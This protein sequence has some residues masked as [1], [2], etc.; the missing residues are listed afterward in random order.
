MSINN[1]IGSNPLVS[2]IIP[3]FNHGM[4]LHKAIES[5]LRQTYPSTEIIVVD[6]GSMDN[7]KAV[8]NQYPGVKYIYQQNQGLSAARNTG[9]KH[10]SGDF[11]VFLDADDW[12]YPRGIEIN[13]SYLVKNQDAAFVSGLYDAVYVEENAIREGKHEVNSDHYK[14]LLQCNYIGMIAAVIFRQWV[15]KEF[16]YDTSLRNCEDYDLYLRVA[17][18][19][20]VFHHQNKIAAYRLH[21][22]NMSAN[23]PS[24]LKGALRVLKRQ[25]DQLRSKEEKQAYEAG[26]VIWK[27]YYSRELYETLRQKR[28][29]ASGEELQMLMRYRPKYFLRYTMKNKK[30]IIKSGIK[31]LTPAFGLKLLNKVGLQNH[32]VPPVGKVDLGDFNQVK[33]FSKEFGYDRGGP[34]DRYYIENFLREES[35]SITGRVLEIGDN[36]YTMQF[37]NGRVTHSDILHVDESNPS[38]T[39]VGD[40]SNAPHLPDNAFDCIILTQTLH[41]IYDFKGALHTCHRILKSGGNLLLTVPGITPIDHGEW[42]ETWYWSF[43]DKAMQ[44]LVAETFPDGTS[45]INTHGNVFAATAFLYG[46]GL[47]EVSKEKLDYNDPHYQVIVSVKAQKAVTP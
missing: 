15:F 23:I 43:T 31:D 6:D 3:C 28:K 38:A 10:S 25:K 18:K 29:A 14:R 34:V 45:E 5:V 19:Y 32:Y 11:L 24:M 36:S 42:K 7:T 20:P 37:G 12:L 26:E 17:R 21:S 16:S 35:G 8:A 33:P 47:A 39:F 9:A 41:L 13:V 44:K 22:S 4:Y 30:A 27:K 1:H 46:M 2:V 40:I